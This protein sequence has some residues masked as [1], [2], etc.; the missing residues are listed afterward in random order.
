MYSVQGYRPG[1]NMLD[2]ITD[3]V[4]TA[5]WCDGGCGGGLADYANGTIYYYNYGTC[6]SQDNCECKN[7]P[8]SDEPGYAGSSCEQIL[9]NPQCRGGVCVE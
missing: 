2:N 7:K 8:N 3:R 9:C 4:P 6:V 1:S 5:Y